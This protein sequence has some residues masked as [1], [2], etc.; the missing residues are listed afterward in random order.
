VFNESDLYSSWM[1][2]F[3]RPIKVG[4]SKSQKLKE[5]GRGNQI[6]QVITSLAWPLYDRDLIMQVM[7]VDAI[8]DNCN[9]DSDG[10]CI[11]IQALSQTT[12][13]DP[14]IHAV[15]KNAV[16]IA[17]SSSML[18]RACPPD[19][20]CVVR[21]KHHH[22]DNDDEP[23]ILLSMMMEVDPKVRAVPQSIQN[24]IT[25]TFLGRMWLALLHVAED[26]RD[27]KRPAHK[28]KI[29]SNRELYDWI[30]KRV[31]VMIHNM[32]KMQKI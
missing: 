24:F 21:S 13:D 28:E 29:E 4:V 16:R 31:G 23:L 18:I 20:P 14:V 15:D 11:A 30:E 10:G 12:N 22:G 19:H 1:P 25:R 9:N 7:A 6:I 8:E 26:V 2:S 32:Q 3:K 27:G 17:F 5:D